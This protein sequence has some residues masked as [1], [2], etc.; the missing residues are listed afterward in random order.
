MTQPIHEGGC[1]CGAIRYRATADAVALSLCHCRSCRL[2][3]GAPALAWSVFPAADFSFI[4]GEPAR[5]RSSP[6]VVRT[7]CATCGT[8]LGWHHD[9]RPATMDVTT[10]TLDRPD[11]FAPTMEIWTSQ[12][13]A[14][15]T[16]NHA[17]PQFPRSSRDGLAE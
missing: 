6:E 5:Y 17:L 3:A 16:P 12:R 11:D 10:A 8:T 9:A 14:W 13:I 15:A 1:L 7:F 4:R 2:A